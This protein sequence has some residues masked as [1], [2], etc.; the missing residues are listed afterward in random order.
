VLLSLPGEMEAFTSS[1]KPHHHP[2]KPIAK[3]FNS[4]IIDL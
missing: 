3:V 1:H 4:P 2:L